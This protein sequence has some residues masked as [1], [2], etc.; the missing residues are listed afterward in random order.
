M[1]ACVISNCV[2]VVDDQSISPALI[3]AFDTLLSALALQSHACKE[4]VEKA[5]G[6]ELTRLKCNLLLFSALM[7]KPVIFLVNM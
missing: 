7:L 1:Y 2:C 6:I 5:G 3:E 4:T